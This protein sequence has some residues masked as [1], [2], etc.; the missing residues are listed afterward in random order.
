MVMV[1]V[2]VFQNWKK[3]LEKHR[4]KLLGGN[5]SSS[6]KKEVNIFNLLHH[7]CWEVDFSD[8]TLF[9]GNKYVKITI[10]KECSSKCKL[11]C[12]QKCKLTSRP[13]G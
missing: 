6:R 7:S 12:K 11:R 9:A 2:S 4:E 13:F 10:I 8:G 1:S 3:E 5:E